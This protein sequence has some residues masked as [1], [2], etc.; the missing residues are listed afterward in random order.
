MYI[1]RLTLRV[2]RTYPAKT[3]MIPRLYMDDYWFS[4][5]D[6]LITTSAFRR[7]A[8]A[9]ASIPD[10]TFAKAIAAV[11]AD[12]GFVGPGRLKELIEPIIGA[13][14][15]ARGLTNFVYN[16]QSFR[17]GRKEDEDGKGSL[18]DD[19]SSSL[20]K[21]SADDLGLSDEEKACVLRRLPP[22]AAPKPSMDRQAKAVSV[23]RRVG[24]TLDKVALA[25]DLRP[26]F[27]ESRE[28]VE[29]IIPLTL[30]R[31]VARGPEGFPQ[32]LEVTM[33]EKQ[34][35]DLCT[36]AERARTKLAA[37]KKFVEK[38]AVPIPESPM[39]VSGEQS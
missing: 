1:V 16:L 22:M 5:F 25:C 8:K 19:F 30:M 36:E 20:Q 29:A 4:G 31:V 24:L 17:R 28:T 10:E 26:V 12:P 15:T 9:V 39:T 32:A 21:A 6:D 11:D 13:E 27:D 2:G 23:A 14:E 7:D 34:V 3:A 38:T 37:L 35:L 18:V 33:T